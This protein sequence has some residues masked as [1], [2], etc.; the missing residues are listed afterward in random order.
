[1]AYSCRTLLHFYKQLS[2]FWLNNI[3][4]A[5][6]CTFDNKKLGIILSSQLKFL[7]DIFRGKANVTIKYSNIG[8]K[9]EKQGKNEAISILQTFFLVCLGF[10]FLSSKGFTF[11]SSELLEI[12]CAACLVCLLGGCKFIPASAVQ[13]EYSLDESLARNQNYDGKVIILL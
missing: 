9:K 4:T 13:S 7:I 3:M 5:I 8:S 12:F 2:M 10:F 1:M 11:S 6:N